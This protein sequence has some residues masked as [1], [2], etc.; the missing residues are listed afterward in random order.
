MLGLA[1]ARTHR[2]EKRELKLNGGVMVVEAQGPAAR[3]GLREGDVIVGLGNQQI[4]SL[5][6]LRGSGGGLEQRPP[7]EHSD[8]PWRLG[9]VRAGAPQRTLRCRCTPDLPTILGFCWFEQAGQGR[10]AH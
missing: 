3:A 6:A 2:A 10:V 1:G 7:G 9:P 8:P 5:K 4:G